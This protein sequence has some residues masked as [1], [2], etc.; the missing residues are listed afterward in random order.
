MSTSGTYSF[1]NVSNN[2]LI[3]E[4]YERLGLLPSLVT[5]QQIISA[6]TSINLLLSEWINRGLNLWTVTRDILTLY[7]NQISYELPTGAVDILEASIR[8]S[9]REVG[10]VPFSSS[11]IAANAFDGNP[12]T[13]CTQNAPNG[14]IG[15]DYGAISSIMIQMV[16]VQANVSNT[17]TLVFECSLDNVNWQPVLSLQPYLFTAGILKFFEVNQPTFSRYFRVRETSG[18]TLNIQELYFNDNIVDLL[19]SPMSRYSYESITNKF[20][21]STPLNYY[22]NRQIKPIIKLWPIPSILYNSIVY[23]YKRAI[24]DVGSLINYL[25]IPQRFFEALCAGLAYKLSIKLKPEM[26]ESLEL[27]YNEA[28]EKAA[29]EDTEKNIPFSIDLDFSRYS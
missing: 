15:I 3:D 10:G 22:I 20:T 12:A 25:D 6:Q 24:Q 2:V 19:M 9:T 17:Y 7:P 21:I 5:A 11:G 28:F 29:R 26:S 16:G 13:A 1:Q 14:N 27:K 18:A 4:A 23:N 8:Q